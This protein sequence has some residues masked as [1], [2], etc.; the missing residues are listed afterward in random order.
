M[1]ALIFL[2]PL[3]SPAVG[4]P[5]HLG[6]LGVHRKKGGGEGGRL[7]GEGGKWERGREEGGQ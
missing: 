5:G 6:F 4:L 3:I 2:A 7:G 1:E